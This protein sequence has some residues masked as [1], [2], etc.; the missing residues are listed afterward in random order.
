MITGN[1]RAI[2]KAYRTYLA[3]L[4]KAAGFETTPYEE[5]EG[6]ITERST[7]ATDEQ[8]N[9]IA[10][11]AQNDTLKPTDLDMPTKIRIKNRELNSKEAKA[12]IE[13]LEKVIKENTY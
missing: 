8:Y 2:S 11:L 12:I 5:I 7:D 9:E 4:P 6:I 10:R 1:T 3:W 13:T